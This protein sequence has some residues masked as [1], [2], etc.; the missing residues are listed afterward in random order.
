MTQI[1]DIKILLDRYY[2]GS[3]SPDEEVSL[4]LLLLGEHE[5][6]PY[7]A[8]R[9][10]L[11]TTLLRA[12]TQHTDQQS[13]IEAPLRSSR[14]RWQVRLSRYGAAAAIVLTVGAG[15]A[16]FRWQQSGRAAEVSL[17]NGKPMAQ[18]QVDRY[19]LQAFAKLGD[20]LDT[21]DEQ[22]EIASEAFE[23]LQTSLNSSLDRIPIEFADEG[24]RTTS[25]K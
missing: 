5:D 25:A 6:S 18:E 12:T 22:Q 3:T 1:D 2:D 7:Y 21:Y 4:Y 9:M 11:E 17:L 10:L 16:L 20:C 23:L 8:D 13:A 14:P 15:L 24:Y 19:A